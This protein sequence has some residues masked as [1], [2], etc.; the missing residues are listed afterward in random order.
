MSEKHF[1]FLVDDPVVCQYSLAAT[2]VDGGIPFLDAVA[3]GRRRVARRAVKSSTRRGY[4]HVSGHPYTRKEKDLV[5]LATVPGTPNHEFLT[6]A[7][8]PWKLQ[9]STTT[10]NS[11]FQNTRVSQM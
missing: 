8:L 11:R 10:T 7:R 9:V 1:A 4:R 2:L 3:S 5:L 6:I